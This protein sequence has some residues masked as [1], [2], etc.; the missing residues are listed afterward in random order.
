MVKVLLN[1]FSESFLSLFKDVRFLIE[2]E[3]NLIMGKYFGKRV[4]R[5]PDQKF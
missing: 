1:Y 4:M 3:N 5:Q 2:V